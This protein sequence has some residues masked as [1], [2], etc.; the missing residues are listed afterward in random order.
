MNYII[1]VLNCPGL[2]INRGAPFSERRETAAYSNII[3]IL[4]LAP[5]GVAAL[6]PLFLFTASVA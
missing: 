3:C 2:T 5:L 4:D 1:A 6:R